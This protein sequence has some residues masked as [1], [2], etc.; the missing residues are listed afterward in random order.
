LDS[1]VVAT[2]H[3]AS[4]PSRCPSLGL[5]GTEFVP[6]RLPVSERV[7][8][9]KPRRPWSPGTDTQASLCLTPEFG[10]CSHLAEE[11]NSPTVAVARG[12]RNEPPAPTD[13]NILKWFGVAAAGCAVGVVV[14]VAMFLFL[15]TPVYEPNDS[16]ESVVAPLVVD[17]SAPLDDSASAAT[18]QQDESGEASHDVDPP[19]L[20]N[21]LGGT[22]T[23]SQAVESESTLESAPAA[24]FARGAPV[25]TG[26]QTHLVGEGETLWDIAINNGVDPGDLATRNGL[27]PDDL[28]VAGDT[29]V[30][31][32]ATAENQP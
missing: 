25:D 3:H 27:A 32:S 5:L 7:C 21:R 17:P 12:E 15:A 23:V 31:P 6:E 19:W 28:I 8:L 11:T 29:L 9:A 26:E 1:D 16:L 14:T 22:P 2:G 20:L 13:D 24:R 4:S 30:I 18:P 10:R